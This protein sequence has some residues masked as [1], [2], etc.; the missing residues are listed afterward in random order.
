LITKSLKIIFAGTPDFAAKHLQAL[1]EDHQHIC[2]VLTQPDRPAGRGQ[3]L[4]KSPVKE[5]ALTKEIHILQPKTLKDTEIQKEIKSLKPDLLIDVAYGLFLPKEVLD[6]PKFGCINVHPS[7]LPRWRGSTPIQ[8]AILRGDKKSGVS[9]MQVD[10]GWDS[11]PVF[12]QE[13]CSIYDTDTA[14][15]LYER[16][17]P[18]GIKNLL[19]V[20]K[21]IG[22]G[23]LKPKKQ[24]EEKATYSKKITPADA[25]IDWSAKAIEINRKIRAF[26]PV[27][28]AHARYGGALV[29]IWQATSLNSY[30]EEKPGAIV[31]LNKDSVDVATGEGILRV[32]KMQF[33][34]RQALPLLD[35][36]NSKREFFEKHKHFN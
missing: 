15:T 7:L 32:Q 27:P 2:A 30:S 20:V 9:I 28:G 6:I 29:Q 16:L 14:G 4:T 18:L 12:Q 24:D 19:E 34:G 31:R 8:Y 26:N 1:L 21:K 11:G 3:K 5:L 10:E 22:F 17:L 13:A 23:D 33:P 35:I 36:L 25:K